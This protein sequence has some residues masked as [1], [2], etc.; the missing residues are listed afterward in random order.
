MKT[1]TKTASE[2]F[3]IPS[4]AMHWLMVLVFIGIFIAVN[5]IDVFPKGSD[6]RQLAKDLHFSL[7]LLVLGLLVLRVAFR[8]LGNT[9]A[10][11]PAPPPWQQKAAKLGHLALYALM[12]LMP[13][14]GWAALSAFGKPI[15][16][17]GLELPTLMAPDKEL[18]RSFMEVHELGGN[19][20]YFL[21]GGHALAALYHH[22]F[23]K[24]STLRGMSLR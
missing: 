1:T 14:V 20:A 16:F 18:G 11:V 5:L 10:I 9:P 23:M 8:L 6:S 3:S 13:L 2:R 24:D 15:P 7:G 4:I 21:I 17:F 19:L 22:Y 12:L